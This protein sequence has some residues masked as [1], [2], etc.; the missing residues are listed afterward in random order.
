MLFENLIGQKPTYSVCRLRLMALPMSGKI[1]LNPLQSNCCKIYV[2]KWLR[3]FISL[4]SKSNSCYNRLG[5]I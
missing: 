1:L 4:P 3:I 5:Q 2:Q